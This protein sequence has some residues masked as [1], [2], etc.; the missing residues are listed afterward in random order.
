MKK[1][2]NLVLIMFGIA[3]TAYS[4]IVYRL[5]SEN[6]IASEMYFI[7]GNLGT[8]LLALGFISIIL[9][10]VGVFGLFKMMRKNHTMTQ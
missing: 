7:N 6:F 3:G 9:I 5:I 2:L 10:I 4:I 8:I 1:V